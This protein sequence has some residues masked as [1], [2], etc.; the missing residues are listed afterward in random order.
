MRTRRF[1][2]KGEVSDDLRTLHQDGRPRRRRLLPGPLEPRQGGPL[3]ARR[4]LHRLVLVEGL[5]QGRDHHLGDPADRLPVGRA[6]T[7]RSTSRA[8]A[9]AARRSPGTPTRRPGSATPTSAA[10]CC[11][12]TARPRRSTAATRSRR[13]R[14]SSTTRSAPGLQ[15]RARQGRPG[16][17]DAGTRP[18][19]WSPPRYVHTIKKWGPDRV[20]GFSPIPAMSMVSHASGARFTSLIGG[21]ML[22]FYDWYADLPVASPQVFGDQTDVPESGDWWDAGYLIMWG[23]NVPVTRTPDAHWMAEARYRG[24]KVVVVAPDYADNVK[25]ADEWLAVA[26]GTD[27]ALAMA[28]GHVILKEFFV[29]RQTPYFADYVEEVHRPA[30]P[31]R[32]RGRP[33]R[34]DLPAG[35]FLTAADLPGARRRGERRIQ[36]RAARRRDRRAGGAERL[37]RPPVRRGRRRA[38]EPRPRRR[39]PAADLLGDRAPRPCRVRAAALRR[40]STGRRARCPA[41]CRCAGSAATWSPPSSTCC[42]RSTASAATGCRGDWPTSYDDADGAVHPGLAGGD[43]RRAGRGGR[44]DR[45]RVRA[46][47]RGVQRPLDDPHGR[48]HQPLVPLRHDLPRLPRR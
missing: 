44:P 18:P 25:F 31:G 37:A 46:E 2:T 26:P 42:S 8:A 13:G 29:D 20:A 41:A 10:C 19:R 47:R 22:S 1:F 45:P 40:P 15:V 16:P 3:H 34:R 11:R 36:D 35:K 6:R 23:S 14:T 21:S 32:P 4:Q 27:G 30:V 39:R 5:R 17:G 38:V 9:R 48:R 28:M 12:C 43:H 33:G 24:Q 7:S